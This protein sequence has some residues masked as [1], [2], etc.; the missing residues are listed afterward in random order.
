MVYAYDQWA[1]MPVKDLYDTQ[2]MLASVQA[3]KDM[4]EKGLAE[5]KDFRKE[6]GD[7]YTP[8][9]AQQ[10]WYNENFNV[11]GF[12]DDLYSRGIDPVRSAEGR[13]ALRRYI[14]SRD[15]GTLNQLKMYSAF[16]QEYLK[17]CAELE[18]KGLY[19]PE[20]EKFAMKG[21]TL[22]NWGMNPW[23]RTSP[24]TYQDLN[25]YTRHI[26][27]KMD[28]SFIES[29][30]NTGLDWFGVSREQRAEALT[31]QIGG[32]LN[33]PLGQWHYQQS[34]KNFEA[35]NGRTPNAA[36]AM[37]QFKNDILTATREYEHRTYKENPVYKR[38]Q[39]AAI[40]D[41]LDS[42]KQARAHA[43]RML[44]R[45]NTP[46]YDE[47]GNAIPG[48]NSSTDGEYN[49]D[50]HVM[51]AGLKN[52]A[53]IDPGVVLNSSAMEL[54][55][56]NPEFWKT[57]RARVAYAGNGAD[58][59]KPFI[60]SYGLDI[61]VI[62]DRFQRD[63]LKRGITSNINLE[64]LG[65]VKM[66]PGDSERILSAQDLGSAIRYSSGIG[67]TSKVKDVH[68]FV[69]SSHHLNSEALG[70]ATDTSNSNG[71]VT[72]YVDGA[73]RSYAPIVVY[74]LSDLSSVYS[75]YYIELPAS[76]VTN[77]GNPEVF[78]QTG[79]STVYDN[80]R[81]IG[82]HR[83]NE[84]MSKEARVSASGQKSTATDI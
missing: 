47:N 9:Q 64:G 29:D 74:D 52:M 33:T 68:T 81:M 24:Y 32:L 69:D 25:Q 23:T 19:N 63:V 11:S 55:N 20:F 4:Y 50:D 82:R 67:P 3:A 16:A 2:M 77:T 27:D 66:T 6:Y 40:D 62:P 17:N 76:G 36:E 51:E 13:T 28:D 83:G 43:Y 22:E 45:A 80:G 8:I 46:G 12:I 37:E 21:K 60:H 49:W 10:D 48:Y 5:L 58:A 7:F 65:I 41:W 59:V 44:E 53:G 26:F 75:D 78:R 57:Y 18:S 14:N 42:N 15:Y 38:K 61:K 34:V 56:N 70:F 35:L 72:A 30:P 79:I 71:I 31:D 54:T 1:R 84:N 39:D 73:V